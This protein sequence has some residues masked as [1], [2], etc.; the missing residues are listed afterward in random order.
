[1]PP[2]KKAATGPTGE[3]A[4]FVADERGAPGR[5]CSVRAHPPFRRSYA[6]PLM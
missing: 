1:M 3:L 6:K 5:L 2:R 4:G